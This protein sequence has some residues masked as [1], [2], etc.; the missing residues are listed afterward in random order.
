MILI[1]N[2][3]KDYGDFR[4]NISMEIPDGRITG[5]IG[6]NA[7]GK[8]TTIKVILGLIKPD[9]GK[10]SVFGT[11]SYK[12][13][14][15]DKE[16]IGV[17]LSEV[18]F[19][20]QLN[21]SDV[22]HILAK[23]YSKF[24]KECFLKKCQELKIPMTK[25][26]REFS[27][28]MKAKLRVLVA[29]TH[30]AKLLIM[31]EPTAGLDVEARNEILDMLRDY[32]AEDEERAILITSHISSD[33][34]GLCDDIYLIHEGKIILHEDTDVILD[35]YGILKMNDV[36]YADLDQSYIIKSQKESYGYACFTNEKKFYQENYPG[37]MVENGGIDELILMMTGG[38]R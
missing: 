14:G 28:G 20:T 5:L 17:S 1:E 31:D 10:V 23:M 3:V 12:L 8:S 21:V 26:I 7:A 9:S 27:T 33:L 29:M 6:K 18:G 25:R 34:E 32:L 16:N 13:T 2:A 37:M 24:D 35:Q 11:K 15:K 4:L 30:Q 38:Y 19:S 22:V 36:Q